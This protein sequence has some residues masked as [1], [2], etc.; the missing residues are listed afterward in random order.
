MLMQ[1]CAAQRVTGLTIEFNEAGRATAHKLLRHR[2]R[3]GLLQRA[4][5]PPQNLGRLVSKIA[6]E[7]RR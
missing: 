3:L 5:P 6:F 7:L 2:D 4:R 1:R